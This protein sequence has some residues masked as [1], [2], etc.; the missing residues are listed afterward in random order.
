[1]IELEFEEENIKKIISKYTG[2]P[3]ELINIDEYYEDEIVELI[4]DLIL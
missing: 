2:A 3:V 4:L 1:M